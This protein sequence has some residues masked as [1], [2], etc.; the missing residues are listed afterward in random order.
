[1]MKRL[2]ITA[3]LCISIAPLYARGKLQ[4]FVERGGNKVTLSSGLQSIDKYQK[5]Y[6]GAAVTVYT[7]GT[8]ALATIYSDAAGTPKSNPFTADSSGFW[9][10]W[11]D[12][13]SYDVAFSGSTTYTLSDL[14]ILSSV[15]DFIPTGSGLFADPGQANQGLTY[16]NVAIASGST[17][18]PISTNTPD[19][20]YRRTDALDQVDAHIPFDL[21]VRKVSGRGFLYPFRLFVR[22]ESNQ[23]TDVTGLASAVYS[24]TT[25][26]ASVAAVANGVG[27]LAAGTY[28][29][30]VAPIMT[31]NGAEGISSNPVAVTV[32]G[33][34][35]V[36]V[37]WTAYAGAASY[38]VYRSTTAGLSQVYF[39]N[40]DTTF[41]DTGGAG[42]GGQGINQTHWSLWLQAEKNDYAVRL[43]GAEIGVSNN[44]GVD[45]G[46]LGTLPSSTIGLQI[47]GVGTAQNT[48]AIEIVEDGSGEWHNGITFEAGSVTDVAIDASALTASV[49]ALKLNNNQAITSLVNGGGSS[50]NVIKLDTSNNI[51]IDRPIVQTPAGVAAV[52]GANVAV[53]IGSAPRMIVL[54]GPTGAFSIDGIASPS[55]GKEMIV[56]N[57]TAQTMTVINESGGAAAANRIL[58]YTGATL[59]CKVFN[60]TY[61]SGTN[62]WLV[63]NC[64]S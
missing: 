23:I 43:A 49:P 47:V 37:S 14:Q 25:A 41:T 34:E 44:S 11:A 13:G 62:R 29:Y 21:V 19:F 18:T 39:A 38:R 20:V 17:A 31:S 45:A 12:D 33:S 5:S 2:L 26:P 42:T 48:T 61:V 24:N 53:A 32:N 54:T 58:T 30:R 59:T 56:Y 50:V 28:W 64:H 10:F 55:G 52:N 35:A 60:V 15:V 36:D 9:S 40:A 51:A 57:N 16:N 4:G 27:T 1:M 6:P 46:A 22:Q 8:L 3:L 63:T 7:A